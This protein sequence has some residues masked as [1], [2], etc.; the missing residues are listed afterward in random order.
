IITDVDTKLALENA[1]V[2]LQDADKKTLNTSTTAADG[3][4]SFTVPCESSFTVVAFKEKYTNESRE[5]A[6]GTTRNAGNDASMALKSLDAIRLEEQQLAEKKKKEEE[7]LVVE[8]KEKEALAVIALKEA[9][10][11]AKEDE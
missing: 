8:K 11:K 4:F 2:I 10:K 9:E 3:K 5:I 6:S 7:R 1:T